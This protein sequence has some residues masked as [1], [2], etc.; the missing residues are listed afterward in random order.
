MVGRTCAGALSLSLSLSSCRYYLSLHELPR[1]S[2]LEIPVI[3]VTC[4][5]N[6]L[7]RVAPV[8]RVRSCARSP[9]RFLIDRRALVCFAPGKCVRLMHRS[10]ITRILSRYFLST[11]ILRNGFPQQADPLRPNLYTVP[12]QRCEVRM[13][14]RWRDRDFLRFFQFV[15]VLWLEIRLSEYSWR[16]LVSRSAIALFRFR[17]EQ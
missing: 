3:L 12:Q 5:L 9:N 7:K 1:A 17:I 4:L 2:C 6:Y 14:A 15:T 16:V 10:L 13:A 8:A 11:R